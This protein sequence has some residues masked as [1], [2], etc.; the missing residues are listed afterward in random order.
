MGVPADTVR[1]SYFYLTYTNT[2]VV[3]KYTRCRSES[4]TQQRES[5]K[6][7]RNAELLW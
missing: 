7:P 6:V 3:Q 1:T 4:P 2:L 5:A